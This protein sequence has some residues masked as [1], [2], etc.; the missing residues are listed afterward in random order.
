VV[1]VLALASL[2]LLGRATGCAVMSSRTTAPEASGVTERANPRGESKAALGANTGLRVRT[3]G[4]GAQAVRVCWLGVAGCTELAAEGVGTQGTARMTFHT[5]S[6]DSTP[7]G[8]TSERLRCTHRLPAQ[9]HTSYVTTLPSLSVAKLNHLLLREKPQFYTYLLS[10]LNDPLTDFL[11]L[12][13]PVLYE[14][15]ISQ[16]LVDVGH[17][18]TPA[19]TQ[20]NQHILH[21]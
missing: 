18:Y 6:P 7:Q 21:F 9:M 11:P 13:Q 12:N 19:F 3:F 8:C 14:V 17:F 16:T 10:N 2:Q 5:H 4:T 15:D 20:C 1:E